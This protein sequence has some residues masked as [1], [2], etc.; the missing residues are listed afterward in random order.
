MNSKVSTEYHFQAQWS[1][2]WPVACE[3]NP[4]S[5]FSLNEF[6][7]LTINGVQLSNISPPQGRLCDEVGGNEMPPKQS[8]TT[9]ILWNMTGKCIFVLLLE[10]YLCTFW[11]VTRTGHGSKTS[12]VSSWWIGSSSFTALYDTPELCSLYT[13]PDAVKGNCC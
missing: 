10:G 6:I 9:G 1:R 13:V 8:P 4:W 5:F 2:P 12:G 7:Q 3:T 11:T